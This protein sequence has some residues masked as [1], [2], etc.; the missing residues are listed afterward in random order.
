MSIIW[1]MLSTLAIG[2]GE[3]FAG[4]VTDRARSHEVS[5]AMFTSGFAL[6][7][8][9]SSAWTGE[10]TTSDLVFG[11]LAGLANGVGILLLYWS[12]AE[13]SVRSAAPVAAVVMSSIPVGWDVIITGTSPSMITALGLALG[14]AAIGVSSYEPG[15]DPIELRGLQVAVLAGAVFGI[16]L[17]LLSFIGREAGGTPLVAQRG[18]GLLVTVAVARLTGPRIFPGHRADLRMALFVGV[19]AT[20][21]VVLFA[22]ALVDGS[23]SV[24]SVVASQYAAVA[25]MLGVIFRGQRMWWWQAVGLVAAS[26]SVVLITLG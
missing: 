5:A 18:V 3:F 24:V 14:V 15:D 19:L 11:C 9:I 20:T 7:V 12:Y 25:V 13:A 4:S 26:V 21:A 23:L 2:S 8:L 1:A 17:V 22:L 16:L 10:P 6:T